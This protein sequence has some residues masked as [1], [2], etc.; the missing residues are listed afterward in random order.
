MINP[1]QGVTDNF[2]GEMYL[3]KSGATFTIN[4]ADQFHMITSWLAGL[5]NSFTFTA[6][7]LAT[8]NGIADNGGNARF[9]TS[10]AH[11]LAVGDRISI[12]NN[13]HGAYNGL[14]EVSGVSDTT[15]FDIAVAYNAAGSSGSVQRG[16]RLRCNA[17]GK[18]RL[19]WALSALPE[20]ANHVFALVP[21]INTTTSS[22]E[23][24]RKYN[25]NTDYGNSSGTEFVDLTSGDDI[26]FAVK[27]VGNSGNFL[28]YTFDL[29]LSRL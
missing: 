14:H 20:S 25:T 2:Y 4:A 23:H 10:A 6:G 22:K 28:P 26:T 27:N 11:G 16:A 19:S 1:L 9:Q 21:V 15:H 7:A 3:S 5:T 29:N 12:N 13:P 18:Y 8:I 24:Q 17:S